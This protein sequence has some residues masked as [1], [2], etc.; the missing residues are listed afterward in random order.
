MSNG[1]IHP[2]FDRCKAGGSSRILRHEASESILPSPI[3]HRLTPPHPPPV[4]YCFICWAS[5]I[6]HLASGNEYL[7]D[8][9]KTPVIQRD[10]SREQSTKCRSRSENMWI[11]SIIVN[12]TRFYVYQTW[13]SICLRNPPGAQRFVGI[14]FLVVLFG[15][16]LA[17][18]TNSYHMV[19]MTR[20]GIEASAVGSGA[21]VNDYTL[22]T[23][24][25]E[26]DNVI[27]KTVMRSICHPQCCVDG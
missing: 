27:I 9:K 3:H 17:G 23:Y 12:T 19:G 16:W 10:Q 21:V 22:W 18:Q 4:L 2:V 11:S 5:G 8:D 20:L 7:W 24:I 26:H 1:E 6:W 25:R 13:R 15:C 14:F